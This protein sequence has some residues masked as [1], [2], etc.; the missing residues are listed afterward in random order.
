MNTLSGIW[1]NVDSML[2]SGLS[3]I[4]VRDKDETTKMGAVYLAKTPYKAW[5]EFQIRQ[6]T[7]EELWQQMEERNTTAVAIVCGKISGNLEVIDVDV[8][9]KPGIDTTLLQDIRTFHPTLFSKLRFHRTPSTGLHIPYRVEGHEV[10]GNLKLAGRIATEA[11]IEL[12]MSKGIKRPSKEVNFL[13]T[14]GEGGYFLA[15]PSLG[16]TVEIDN[17]IPTI[18]WEEREALITLCMSYSEIVKEAPKPKLGKSQESVYNENPFEHYNNSVDPVALIQEFGWKYSHKNAKFYWFTR[19]GKDKG[20]SASWNVDKR[21]FFIFTTSTD[22]E[23]M[24]GYHPATLLAELKFQ[25]NKSETYWH[26]VNNGYGKVKPAVEQKI[27]KRAAASG[28]PIPANFS[29]QAKQSYEAT[30]QQLQEDH[31]Y[32]VFIKYDSESEKL[33]VSYESLLYVA[34]ELGLYGY[35]GQI[36]YVSG[37][38][39]E[40]ITDRQFQDIL[41]SYIREEEADEYEKLCNVFE[42]FLKEN[43]KFIATRLALLEESLIAKDTRNDCYKFYQN[44]YIHIT[45][46]SVDFSTYDN[47]DRL[48]W[49]DRI[50]LRDYVTGKG[51]RFVEYLNLALVKPEDAKPAIGY[52]AHEWKDETTGFIIVLT[53]SCYDPRMGGGSGKNVFCNLLKLTTTYTSK[54][55]IQGKFDESYFQ[56]WNG[57]RV[58]GISDLHKNFDFKNFKEPATGSFALKKL[59]KDITTVKVEDAP[60]FIMQTNYSY[61]DSDGGLIRRIIPLEFTDFFTRCGGLD[62]H[63]GI[64]FPNG[65]TDEDYSGYDNYIA[66]CVQVWMQNGCKLKPGELTEEGWLK[67]FEQNYGEVASGIISECFNDFV[68]KGEITNEDFKKVISNYYTEHNIPRNY[69]AKHKVISDALKAYCDKHGIDVKTDQTIR[70]SAVSTAKGRKF[71]AISEEGVRLLNAAKS[72]SDEEEVTPF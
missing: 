5:K 38:V 12:Q 17:P 18:T 13:E 63:F 44:G 30:V 50:Q 60:K 29:D 53:E 51:G 41:K 71:K 64:H 11:E 7:K 24:R 72:E 25:G 59:W 37:H 47:F 40:K 65:W 33:S 28:K 54:P 3:I 4:P 8:K 27:V 39:V 57:E 32:G 9:F 66:E 21:M 23:G 45:K 36:V 70:V 61:T 48:V 14:R 26:L 52:L 35:Q 46:E 34:K 68:S 56:S 19:P 67:K 20:V 69:E 58:F 10:P 6:I 49:K 1:S 31:P 22:L 62:V 42:K 2:Q 15:P 43:T 16:Y 55:S